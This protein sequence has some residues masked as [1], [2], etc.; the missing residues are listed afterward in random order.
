[1]GKMYKNWK[2][3]K[4]SANS[5]VKLPELLRKSMMSNIEMLNLSLH[6]HYIMSRSLWVSQ[7]ISQCH[8]DKVITV[9]KTEK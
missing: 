3:N 9:E 6:N 5:L 2:H 8:F 4:F 1:M 7:D